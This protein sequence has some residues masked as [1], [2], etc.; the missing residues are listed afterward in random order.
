MSFL[1]LLSSFS[2]AKA[3]SDWRHENTVREQNRQQAEIERQR[4]EAAHEEELRKIELERI[5]VEHVDKQHQRQTQLEEKK[6]YLR[7]VTDNHLAKTL[8]KEM[9]VSLLSTKTLQEHKSLPPPPANNGSQATTLETNL[10]EP[11]KTTRINY[12][13][14]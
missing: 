6:E 5:R 4:I 9:V 10:I 11:P 3:L 13:K 12:S 2:P 8:S 1:E 14:E 7:F